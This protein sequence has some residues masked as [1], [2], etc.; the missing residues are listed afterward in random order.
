MHRSLS[1]IFL[2]FVFNQVFSQKLTGTVKD[3]AGNNLSFSSIEIK[4]KS[5]GTIANEEGRFSLTLSPGS[6]T[7]ICQHIGYQ[8]QEK[9]ITISSENIKLDFE[10]SVQQLTLP[11]VLVKQGEDPAYAIIR[12]AINKRRFYK[13]EFQKF[14]TEVYTK[15]QLKLRDFPKKFFGQKIDF[16]DGDTAKNKML[17][18][19]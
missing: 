19:E 12:N 5:I 14:T 16:E 9:T 3:V 15:G 11:E 13:D 4:N 10:L 18:L 6:Y 17:Y 7:V 1:L 8:R 2:T